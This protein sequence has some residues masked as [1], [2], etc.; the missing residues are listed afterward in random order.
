MHRQRNA[1]GPARVA[2]AE[3]GVTGLE[4]SEVNSNTLGAAA[5]YCGPGRVAGRRYTCV[6]CA[7]FA[8]VGKL[9]ESRAPYR[10]TEARRA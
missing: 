1:P 10:C 5:C 9:I 6:T 2:G 4:R 3:R 8:R 7:A